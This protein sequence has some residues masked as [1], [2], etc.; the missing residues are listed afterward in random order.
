MNYIWINPVV[1]KMYKKNLDNIKNKLNKNGF[2]VISASGQIQIVKNK[3]KNI[4]LTSKNTVL[5]TRCPTAINHINKNKNINKN[6]YT[7]PKIEPILIHT[8]KYLYD[9]HIKDSKENNLIITTPCKALKELGTNVFKDKQG[10]KFFTWLEICNMFNIQRV[11]KCKSSPIPLGFFR[12]ISENVL[13]ISGEDKFNE[14][15]LQKGY[16]IIEMLYCSGG[17]NNGDGI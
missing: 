10:I 8:A 11:S 12:D 7:V 6:I 4:I 16:D 17:C 13:E 5:D 2:K 3:F 1:E 15:F 9:I 14:S